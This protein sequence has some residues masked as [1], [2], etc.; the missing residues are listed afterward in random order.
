MYTS[1]ALAPDFPV[2]LYSSFIIDILKGCFYIICLGLCNILFLKYFDLFFFR[3]FE[4]FSDLWSDK[5]DIQNETIIYQIN[6]ISEYFSSGN[7]CKSVH[8]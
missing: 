6:N 7:A 5:W 1:V 3:W 4:V 2:L 8:I